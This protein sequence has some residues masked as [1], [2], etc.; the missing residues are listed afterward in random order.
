M[1]IDDVPEDTIPNMS[2][3]WMSVPL[4][5]LSRSRTRAVFLKS[6]WRSSMNRMKM[7]PDASLLGRAGGRMM[8]SGGAA[9]G[10]SARLETRPPCTSTS[11]AIS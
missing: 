10:G 9:G 7:R 6:R 1:A 2:P 4:I 3:W 8:P 11:D 5:F